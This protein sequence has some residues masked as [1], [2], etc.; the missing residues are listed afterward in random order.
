MVWEVS[1]GHL[2]L[3]LHK[4]P[5]AAGGSGRLRGGGGGARG[6]Q[7]GGGGG[8]GGVAA[9]AGGDVDVD[10]H[11]TAIALSPAGGRVA[12]GHGEAAGCCRLVLQ[13]G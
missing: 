4:P 5:P 6:P 8:G 10:G 7:S 11:V 3:E 12:A 2:L 1:T 13:G 9:A